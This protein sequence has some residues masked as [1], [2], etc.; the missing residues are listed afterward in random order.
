MQSLVVDF[1]NRFKN[2]SIYLDF[3]YKNEGSF[4]NDLAKDKTA[5]MLVSVSFSDVL[6]YFSYVVEEGTSI[7]D[8]VALEDLL[9]WLKRTSDQLA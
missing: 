7:I 2:L 5:Y 8:S 4:L 9:E 1:D 6:C 3:I